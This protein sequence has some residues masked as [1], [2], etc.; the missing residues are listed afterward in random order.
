MKTPSHS[1]QNLDIISYK[2]YYE[3][4]FSTLLSITFITAASNAKSR[5]ISAPDMPKPIFYFQLHRQFIAV[6]EKLRQVRS[7]VD[8][9]EVSALLCKVF[10]LTKVQAGVMTYE[11]VSSRVRY[12]FQDLKGLFQGTCVVFRDRDSRIPAPEWIIENIHSREAEFQEEID[13]LQRRIDSIESA[14]G[15]TEDNVGMQAR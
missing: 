5:C 2:V 15:S 6:T 11:Q 13:D 14:Q 8:D 9:V 12:G 7:L 10:V 4:S 1:T 3:C